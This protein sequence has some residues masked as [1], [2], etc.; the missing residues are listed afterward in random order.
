[1]GAGCR[2]QFR[3]PVGSADKGLVSADTAPGVVYGVLPVDTRSPGRGRI[4]AVVR[5]GIGVV[6]VVRSGRVVGRRRVDQRPC[7]GEPPTVLNLL[8]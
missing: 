4:A 8:K 7:R 6:A 3:N 5:S 2:R 1:V